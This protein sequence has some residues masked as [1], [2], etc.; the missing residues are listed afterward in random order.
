MYKDLKRTCI[1]IVL[2]IKPFVW[3]HSRRRRR[4]GLL[5]NLW[6]P[7]VFF[8]FHLYFTDV[9]TVNVRASEVIIN[10]TDV[11]TVD[12]RASEVIINFTDVKTVNVR[13]SEVIINFTDVKTVNVRASEVIIIIIIKDLQQKCTS[14]TYIMASRL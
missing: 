8:S 9:K 13:A 5:Q 10:F 14:L 4:R 12:V 2:L 3:W 11:K 6:L 1:T 7:S